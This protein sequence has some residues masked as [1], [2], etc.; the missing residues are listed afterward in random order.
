MSTCQCCLVH[1]FM[2]YLSSI[3]QTWT[4]PWPRGE[5]AGEGLGEGTGEVVGLAAGTPV[6]LLEGLPMLQHAEKSVPR[7]HDIV[8][9]ITPF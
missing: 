2:F 7:W 6:H 3:H 5:A 4:F 1:P 9:V 8:I